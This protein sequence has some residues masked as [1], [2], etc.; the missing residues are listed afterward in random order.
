MFLVVK[1]TLRGFFAPSFY[2]KIEMCF[3][4]LVVS[5]L[6]LLTLK[7]SFSLYSFKLTYPMGEVDML[8]NAHEA[9]DSLTTSY[10]IISVPMKSN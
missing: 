10:D 4:K 8:F 3:A 6:R 1:A 2:L 7:N 5:N 9:A